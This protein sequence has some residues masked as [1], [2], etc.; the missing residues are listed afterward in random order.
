[1]ILIKPITAR[2]FQKILHLLPKMIL[3][4]C[5][6]MQ[7]FCVLHR[8]EIDFMP[9]IVTNCTA[10]K[11]GAKAALVMDASLVG[12][13]LADTVAQWQAAVAGCTAV[14]SAMDVYMGR[15]ISEARRAAHNLNASLYFV[16]A[17]MGVVAAEAKIPAYDL[18][19]VQVSG[20]LALALAQ[21]QAT[22]AE[23]WHL[24]S[25]L[26]LSRLIRTLA[27]EQVL[28]ALPATYLKML[29]LDLA[30]IR[31]IDVARLRIFTS[32]AGMVEI[33]ATL[34]PIVMPYDER[35]ESVTGFAG[36]QADFP[37]RALRHFVEELKGT[38]KSLQASRVL[39]VNS[40]AS[41]TTRRTPLRKRLDDSQLKALIRQRWNSCQ[42]RSTQ[43][44]RALRD[45][46][47][48][49]C[50]QGRFVQLW[51]EIGKELSSATN[52]GVH[53]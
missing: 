34:R 38:G 39:I 23:W 36:T 47:L 17:G 48:V 33:P 22:P 16:S 29:A 51:R 11:R 18:T 30:E 41:H 28:V 3:S 6:I 1:M 20:G 15:S 14:R 35:L 27:D 10:K 12:P 53:G 45:E 46:E 13:T 5:T 19:P 52:P 9:V 44:L 37:Q 2:Q 42:G 40:L 31:P 24:L 26:G 4:V 7:I 49:A 43:L 32:P 21:H 25:G 8:A 50:E